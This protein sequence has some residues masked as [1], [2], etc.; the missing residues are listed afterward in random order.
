VLISTHDPVDD[1]DDGSRPTETGVRSDDLAY[2]IYTS[3]STGRPKGVMVEHRAIVNTVA[4]CDRDLTIRGDDRVLFNLPYTFDP[5]LC[6]IFPTLAAGARLVLAAPGE[7]YDPH[8]L[9]ERVLRQGVTVVE[10]PPAVLRLM[11]DDPLIAA[12][13]T[14]RWVGCG[15]EAMPRDLPGRLLELLD[16][17]VYNLYGPTEAA[18]NS[19]WWTCRR[20]EPRRSVPIGRPIA[21]ARAYVLDAKL[22][23]VPPGVP[24]EL[25]IGG[26]GL[27]RGYLN[28]P[29][30]TAERFVDDPY[31]TTPGARL[32]RTGDRCRWLTD[33]TLEFLGRLDNQVKV[34]GFRVELG[35]VEAA[36]LSHPRVREAAVTAQAHAGETRLIAY[37]AGDG[38]GE[39][40]TP[41]AL[42]RH[43]KDKLPDSMV[44]SGF[45]VL[46]ALPRT[47]RGKID[48]RAL[49][50]PP[51]D[52]PATD[53]PYVAPRTP[54]E[55]FL[56][57]LWREVLHL[58][59]VGT[60]DH[61]FELGGSSIQGAMLIN[62]L[63]QKLGEQ[64]YVI[65]LFDSPTVAGLAQYV[66]G[67]FPDTVRRLFGPE[68][69]DRATSAGRGMGPRPGPRELIVTLQPEGALSP[70][71]MVHP[72]GGIVVCYQALA[73]RLGRERP[74]HGIRSRGLH[75]E[76]E[77]PRRMEEMAAEYVA[78]MR[79]IQPEGPYHLGGWSA[80][81]VIALEMA[82]Q[83]LAQGEPV[84]LLALLD[85]TPPAPPSTAAEH[86]SSGQEYG[87]DLSLEELSRLGPEEQLPYLWQHALKLGLIEPE[88]PLQVAEQVLNELKRLFHQ[89]MVLVNEYVVRPY[90]GRVTLFRPSEAP[91]A[92]ATPRDKGWTKLLGDVDVQ[93]VPGQHHSMVKEP[94]VQVLAQRL[95]AC[96]GG[97]VG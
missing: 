30:L 95:K 37:V 70:W 57:G 69:L 35:D 32:Y 42:R 90:P 44:P 91:V 8:R 21:N 14:L 48:H 43:L 12:C 46:P 85:T 36:L 26:A 93:F 22:R 47:T 4:W 10:S 64:V 34:R 16:V 63:Q 72:P 71:F 79:A 41:Q 45:I 84:A 66:R 54:L 50:A 67:E 3:G 88:V 83:I 56:A 92:V 94:H 31:A 2:V 97:T 68:S 74:F 62:R 65:A 53:R 5:S 89:H 77:L 7:E 17:A 6:L 19:T 86:E 9:L 20:D 28:D 87:L 96:L 29:A 76:A 61:F 39:P 51:S 52:R 27:A 81:G 38:E 55:E 73:Y 11:L 15:G 33:G 80:G 24:G 59:R 78:A 40:P 58:D 1:A 75:G 60:F 18:V 13:R 23:P 82:H 25:C 49:P